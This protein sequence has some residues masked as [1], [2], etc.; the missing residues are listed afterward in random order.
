MNKEHSCYKL[1][2]NNQ[3]STGPIYSLQYN[4]AQLLKK[5]NKISLKQTLF[6]QH[7]IVELLV[8]FKR[9]EHITSLK[10]VTV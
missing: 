1:Q 8:V 2:K 10:K 6:W 3:Y 9:I 7:A 4:T 5:L